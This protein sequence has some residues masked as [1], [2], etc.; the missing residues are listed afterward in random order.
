MHDTETAEMH[1]PTCSQK[2]QDGTDDIMERSI[3][4]PLQKC[5]EHLRNDNICKN[6]GPNSAVCHGMQ[7]SRQ[8]RASNWRLEA[9]SRGTYRRA[10][11]ARIKA[12]PR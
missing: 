6:D 4:K 11:V 3:T 8:I 9:A 1:L 10:A 2:T 12:L 7:L 5:G